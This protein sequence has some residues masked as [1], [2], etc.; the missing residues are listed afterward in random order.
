MVADGISVSHTGGE[1]KK[2]NCR[3]AT[4]INMNKLGEQFKMELE[5]EHNAEA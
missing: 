4:E 3:Q 1:R 5:F 2:H